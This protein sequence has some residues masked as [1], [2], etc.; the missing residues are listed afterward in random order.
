MVAKTLKELYQQA[1]LGAPT[2]FEAGELFTHVTDV[3]PMDADT[4][5][6]TSGQKERLEELLAKRGE[7]YPLQYLLGEWEFYSL[8]FRVGPG[9]LIPRQDTEV[10]VDAALRALQAGKQSRP[11]VLDLCS[12]SGCVAIAIKRNHPA[13]QVTAQELS[14]QACD[15]LTQNIA[16]NQVE[17]TPHRSDLR[18]YT[19]PVPL[20]LIVSNPPYISEG[21]LGELQAEVGFEP[22]AALNGGED[23]LYYFR[24]I[25][26]R[27]REQL[28][29]GGLLL[30]EIGAGQEQAVSAILRENGMESIALHKD[31]N[32]IV[33]VVEGRCPEGA[34]A[35]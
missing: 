11:Q 35:C 10:L 1:L 6:A 26:R 12:G 27:F 2:P 8:P 3:R 9:V 17:I 34:K 16:L 4:R 32:G 25:A 19:H 14:P 5:P 28:C 23:G 29:P 30:L 20:D 13:A 7:G 22:L 24:A 15:Y 33:R 21:Q 31:Y 18:D